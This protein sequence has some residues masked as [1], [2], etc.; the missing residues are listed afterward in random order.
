MRIYVWSDKIAKITKKPTA[1][2]AIFTATRTVI[3]RRRR[4][5]QDIRMTGHKVTPAHNTYTTSTATKSVP[6]GR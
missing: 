2:S 3:N 6:R 4:F 1:L 5:E